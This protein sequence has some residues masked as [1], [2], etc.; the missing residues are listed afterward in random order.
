MRA[1]TLASGCRVCPCASEPSFSASEP[2][3][4][5]HAL[6][7]LQVALRDA[8]TGPRQHGLP[9]RRP[10]TA[11]A[12]AMSSPLGFT[13]STIDWHA[14]YRKQSK[15]KQSKAKGLP[16]LPAP[17]TGPEAIGETCTELAPAPG[18]SFT[19]IASATHALDLVVLLGWI[20]WMPLTDSS[21]PGWIPASPSAS[22]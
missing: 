18:S 1:C 11:D 15:A 8:G 14:I 2:R 16:P 9:R 5:R 4:P 13:A 19:C 6:P 3:Q 17:L 21:P 20:S 10:P 22:A 12:H 7:E